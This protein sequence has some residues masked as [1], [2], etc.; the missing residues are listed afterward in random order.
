MMAVRHHPQTRPILPRVR[1]LAPILGNHFRISGLSPFERA[2]LATDGTFTILLEALKKTEI[3]VVVASNVEEPADPQLA[4][5]LGVEIDDLIWRR[6][7]YLVEHATQK[8]LVYACSI[9]NPDVFNQ[10]QRSLLLNSTSG[11]GRVISQMRSVSRRKLLG[12]AMERG[13]SH[14][15]A[16]DLGNYAESLCKTYTIELDG[17]RA[18][19]ITEKLPRPLFSSTSSED[20]SCNEINELGIKEVLLGLGSNLGDRAHTLVQAVLEL[21]RRGIVFVEC[22]SV[23]E[24]TPVGMLSDKVF[25]NAVVAISFDGSFGHLLSITQEVERVLGRQAGRKWADRP[26]DI[27]ILYAGKTIIDTPNLQIPHP[28]AAQ[29][30]FVVGPLLEV[31]PETMDPLSHSRIGDIAPDQVA[32]ASNFQIIMSASEF[33][34]AVATT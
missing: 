5:L 20:R 28:L 17:K 14:L 8:P 34:A 13:G 32:A 6:E 25:A 26:I 3:D 19:F 12:F 29:R 11:L 9:V 7:V 15:E 2:L 33:Q 1:D 10:E 30:A 24:T 18:A 27:D 31:R 23:Y 22:S 21:T 4:E 16:F